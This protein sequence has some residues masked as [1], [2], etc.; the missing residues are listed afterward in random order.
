[1]PE[2]Y[3]GEGADTPRDA[4][5]ARHTAATDRALLDACADAWNTASVIAWGPPSYQTHFRALWTNEALFARFDVSDTQPWHTGRCRDGCLWEEEVVEIFVDPTGTGT[6]YAELEIN[7]VNVVCDLH[8]AQLE[9][10]RDVRLHWDF[11]ALRTTV[12]PGTGDDWTAVACMP[13]AD[14]ATLS[15]RVADLLPV[16]PGDAWHFNVFRI[17]RPHGPEEPERDAIYAAWSL[18]EGGSFHAPD[19]FRPLRFVRA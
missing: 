12:C 9:P 8:I 14:F 13:F 10:E 1:M 18:P 2:L 11:P 16:E 5:D 17:K 7:P 3:R 6:D 15:P 19:A 4:Y